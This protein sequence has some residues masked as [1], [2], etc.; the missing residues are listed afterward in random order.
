MK[1]QS[2][3]VP[4]ASPKLPGLL[5]QGCLGSVIQQKITEGGAS[6]QA[7]PI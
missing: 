4:F 2:I 3:S 1:L 6:L 7:L 5:K